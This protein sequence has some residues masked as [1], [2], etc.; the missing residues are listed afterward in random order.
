[1]GR[2]STVGGVGVMVDELTRALAALGLDIHVISPYYNFNRKGKTGYL[3]AEGN[4][5][6][7]RILTL[8]GVHWLQN[9]VTYIGFEYCE[10]GI[11]QVIFHSQKILRKFREMNMEYNFTFCITLIIS[12]LHIVLGHLVTS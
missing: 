7:L 1:M 5:S 9:I 2:F 4:H 6:N 11:H 3:E 12:L 10:V 8:L